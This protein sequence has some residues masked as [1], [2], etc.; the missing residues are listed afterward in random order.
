MDDAEYRK[1]LDGIRGE[2]EDLLNRESRLEA[3][4]RTIRRRTDALAR[5][6]QGLSALVGEDRE[7]ESIGITDAIREI[8]REA[9]NRI[10]KPTTVRNF[11]RRKEFPLDK[12]QNPL[13]VIH[14]TLRR[15]EGQGEV[16][17]IRKSGKTFYKWIKSEEITDD[18][19]PF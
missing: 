13:A 9:L 10:W 12:Y 4:L 8:L 19:I 11:L 5:A 17:A 16:E 6:A 18:D 1:T 7:D 3:R 2:L 15:L 14:T